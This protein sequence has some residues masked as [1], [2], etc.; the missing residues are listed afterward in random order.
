MYLLSA[1]YLDALVILCHCWW[2]SPNFS[3]YKIQI[4]LYNQYIA[5]RRDLRVSWDPVSILFSNQLL[6]SDS[7]HWEASAESI[8]IIWWFS[9]S[10]TPIQT[11]ETFSTSAIKLF[12]FLIICVFTELALF[13]SFKNFSLTF[14]TWLTDW[15]KR[16]S[17]QPVSA[18]NMLSSLSSIISSFWFKVRYMT[19]SL[20]HLEA[21]VG[22]L[23]WFQY[24][25]LRK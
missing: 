9:V 5:H 22:L 10:V 16:P 3:I 17:F 25:C 18:F 1:S 12:H 23:A 19:L 21:T 11:T 14:T 2:Y 24:S 4:S 15:C 8:I 7:I 6:L 20:E 13:I